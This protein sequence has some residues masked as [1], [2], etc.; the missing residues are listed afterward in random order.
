MEASLNMS[1][2]QHGL[3]NDLSDRFGH[4]RWLWFDRVVCFA[5]AIYGVVVL[6]T[7]LAA[8]HF[9]LPAEDAVILHQYSRNLAE[10]G[11]ITY[12]AGGPHAEGATDFAWMGLIATGIRCGIA[13]PLFTALINFSTL[14]VLGLGMLRLAGLRIT[15]LRLLMI[16]GAAGLLP[17][18]VAAAAGFAILPDALLLTLLVVSFAR[19][20]TTLTAA[21]ALVLCL[22]RPDG[23]VFVVP[24][25]VCLLLRPD[26]RSAR[27]LR[28]LLV[29][30]LPGLAYFVWRMAYFHALF[31]LPFTVKSDVHRNLGVLV[32]HS[33]T[34][35]LKYLFFDSTLLLPLWWPHPVPRL[36]ALS[37]GYP[38]E[39][40]TVPL[41]ISLL[42]LPTLFYWAMR[43]DQNVGDRFFFYLPLAAALLLALNWSALNEPRRRS[44]LRIGC[45]A[46][47]VFLLGP[48]LREF[49]SFR[50][51]QFRDVQAIAAD[52][53]RLP[54]RGALLTTEA[55]FITYGSGWIAYDAW[56][57]NTE[58]FAQQF[59]QPS[60]VMALHPDLIVL[61][62]DLPESCLPQSEWL[63]AYAQRSWPDMT[64]NLILGARDAGDYQ[65]WLISYGSS[66]YRH[67]KHWRYGEGDR[68]CF[69]VR[70]SSP[71]F[72]GMV[73][74]LKEHDAVGPPQ[75][76]AI[77]RSHQD[78][79]DATPN[80]K[81]LH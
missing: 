56:G 64:R 42:G 38:F 28:I 60:D 20:R 39:L 34:S 71:L 35:S 11:T 10:Q 67:R 53:R 45:A 76:M 70:E 26:T 49:R 77:E 6:L 58:R 41:A 48:L 15:P 33:F 12:Y 8:P 5:L 78:T 7:L 75:S 29:F 81:T 43:L 19:Q 79:L 13:P 4:P 40:N 57:L 62:P 24:L 37:A 61:H 74:V 68:E 36:Q 16:A 73:A 14:L 31:P 30:L 2:S 1:G 46:F 3:L 65:L 22:F 59:I 23:V 63:P 51:Y 69:L 55:G 21:L 66:F 47:V 32:P 52:L 27:A 17:Q 44:I 54:A 18:I 80:P 50:Y 25:L 72:A 9:F